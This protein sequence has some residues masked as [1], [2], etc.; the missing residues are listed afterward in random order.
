MGCDI[1]I[2]TERKDENGFWESVDFYIPCKGFRLVEFYHD[3][4]YELFNALAGVRGE[5]RRD[6]AKG[7]P[8]DASETVRKEH[9]DDDDYHSP[10]YLNLKEL[11]ALSEEYVDGVKRN[12]M[13]S[14]EA[15]NRLIGGEEPTSWC[16]ATGDR[17]WK[18]AEWHSGDNPL[19]YIMEKLEMFLSLRYWDYERPEADSEDFRVVFWFDN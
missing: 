19:D 10:S 9:G 12:G 14:P 13:V 6:V 17:S 5:G 2:F 1:H 7:F 15:Y 4:N 3:R 16:K 18:Y 8:D 11:K